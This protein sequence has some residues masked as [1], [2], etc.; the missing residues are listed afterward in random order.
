MLRVWRPGAVAVNGVELVGVLLHVGAQPLHP[1]TLGQI[2]EF[3]NGLHPKVERV[4]EASRCRQV[5]RW[6]DWLRAPSGPGKRSRM[7]G[8]DQ[9]IAGTVRRRRPQRE[10][11]QIGEIPDAP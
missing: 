5:G 1:A 4:D 11:R 6:F 7:Q 8:I 10:I 2:D 3:R 9:H